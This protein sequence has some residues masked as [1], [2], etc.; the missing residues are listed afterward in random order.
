[1]RPAYRAYLARLS[2]V[3]RGRQEYPR[4]DWCAAEWHGQRTTPWRK[5][6]SGP[7][8]RPCTGTTAHPAADWVTQT[9]KNL[10]TDVQ[11]VGIRGKFLIRDRDAKHPALIDE[12]LADAG[13]LT[14]LTG[15]RMPCTNSI[16]ER[17]VRTHR[18]GLLDHTPI[19]NEQHLRHALRAYELHYNEHRTHRSLQTATPLPLSPNRSNPSESPAF[20]IRRHDRLSGDLHEYRHPA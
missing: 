15:I 4:K 11:D 20:A 16:M 19:R 9:I 8:R 2:P 14:V 3:R 10:A 5:N 7:R 17:W 6:R 18:R 1:M 13:I 12:I